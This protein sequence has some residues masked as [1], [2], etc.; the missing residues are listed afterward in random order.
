MI[1]QEEISQIIKAIVAGYKPDKVILFGSYAYG[2]PTKDSDIDLL[3][4]KDDDLPKIK[5]NRIARSYLRDFKFP[6]DVIVKS[7]EEF[8]RL[9]DV[10]GTVVY[11]ANKYGKIVYG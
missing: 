6:V 8:E 5:R 7:R 9:K 3:L 10:I 4:I 11:T 2:E 1:T